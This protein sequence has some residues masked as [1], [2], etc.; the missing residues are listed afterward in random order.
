MTNKCYIGKVSC[1]INEN[2][3]NWPTNQRIGT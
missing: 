1:N 3:T 2:A